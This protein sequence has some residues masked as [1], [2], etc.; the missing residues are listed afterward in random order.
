MVYPTVLK[1][2]TY[3][4][5][6]HTHFYASSSVQCS[7]LQQSFGV[8]QFC[9][10]DAGVH[11]Y[12]GL[13][14]YRTFIASFKFLGD[15]VNHSNYWYCGKTKVAAPPN[16]KGAPQI[17]T[18]LNKYFLVLCRL[19]LWLLEQDLAY[20]FHPSQTTISRDL[21]KFSMCQTEGSPHLANKGT[22]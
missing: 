8:S 7:L 16:N 14:D 21:D 18:P 6:R 13:P 20:R 5:T 22:C 15:A 11:L 10:D 2:W 1:V 3:V 4:A 17:L 9:R 12:A 19:R